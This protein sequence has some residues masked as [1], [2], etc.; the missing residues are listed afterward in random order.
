MPGLQAQLGEQYERI[1]KTQV[2]RIQIMRIRNDIFW[3]ISGIYI[4]TFI[5]WS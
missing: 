4:D 3:I 5:M 2:L 1:E